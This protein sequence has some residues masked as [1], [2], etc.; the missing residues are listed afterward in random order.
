MKYTPNTNLF[1]LEILKFSNAF[2]P[3]IVQDFTMLVKFETNE[4][5]IQILHSP[6]GIN[7]FYSRIL[8]DQ[9]K[10]LKKKKT[11]NQNILKIGLNM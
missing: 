8:Q 3:K 9:E 4:K 10:Q 5:G 2:E 7:W 6:D 11:Y 1:I